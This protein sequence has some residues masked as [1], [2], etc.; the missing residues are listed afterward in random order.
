MSA[1]SGIYLI[2]NNIN[3][4][5][6]IGKSENIGR[7]WQAH[8]TR[9]DE[10]GKEYDK[11]LYRAFRKYGINQFSFSIIELCPP[12]N[13]PKRE[14]YWIKYYDA[15]RNGYNCSET[16]QPFP[17]SGEEHFNHKLTAQDVI[18]IRTSYEKHERCKEVYERYKD[19]IGWSGFH[20]IW[21]GQT[22]KKIKMEV[23]TPE[24]IEFHKHNVAN[25]GSENGRSILT[26]EMVYDIRL[27]KAHGEELKTVYQDYQHLGI[28]YKSFVN[29]WYYCN[30]KNI[31]VE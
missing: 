8:L 31:I 21:T 15:Y 9:W 10:P 30:W 23:Y 22:W 13:L 19:N 18:N 27:R 12:E 2:E 14:L 1:L 28:T 24:N 3:H 4:K 17:M 7:R 5:K 11:A 20:K 16:E 25:K 29:V 26:E 6:Y